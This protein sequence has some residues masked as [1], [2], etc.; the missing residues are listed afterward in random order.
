MWARNGD[1]VIALTVA[2]ATEGTFTIIDI[3]GDLGDDPGSGWAVGGVP[4]GTQNATLTRKTSICSPNPQP[5]GSFGTD[6]AT[7]EW[8]IGDS[9]SGWDTIG[10]YTGCSTTPVI[11]IASPSDTS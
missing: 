7:S 8:N 4:N 9:D 5:L 11:S 6:A 1:D 3:M 2:G 10:S